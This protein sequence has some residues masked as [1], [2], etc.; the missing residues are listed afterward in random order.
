MQRFRTKFRDDDEWTDYSLNLLCSPDADV[1][2]RALDRHGWMIVQQPEYADGT[3]W[4]MGSK[5]CPSWA[6]DEWA[7]EEEVPEDRKLPPQL[8]VIDGDKKDD[9]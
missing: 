6:S 5:P 1:F 2:A 3:R 4:P 9:A 7:D 8:H